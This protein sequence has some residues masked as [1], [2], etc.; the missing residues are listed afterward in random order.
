MTF[1]WRRVLGA[2][3]VLLLVNAP[4]RPAD[5][6]CGG[7]SLRHDEASVVSGQVINV[8]GITFG[9]DCYD[10][11]NPP[12]GVG[13]HGLPLRDIRILFVQGAREV[14][15]AEGSAD[16][17]YMF[18]LDVMV[19]VELEPG[20]ASLRADDPGGH[21]S[22]PF[23]APLTVS[24]A[25]PAAAVTSVASFGPPA[26][27]FSPAV[28]RGAQTLPSPVEDGPGRARRLLAV[29]LAVTLTTTGALVVRRH[30][31]PT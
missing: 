28:V 30:R 22:S 23:G 20:P 13:P 19:P 4:P 21:A 18:Q 9:S 31:R 16:A 3:A 15:V 14:L 10:T 12:P 26:A 25:T 24:R 7:P 2:M 27:A 17:G 29:I 5:A 6:S 11:G 1:G 8:V